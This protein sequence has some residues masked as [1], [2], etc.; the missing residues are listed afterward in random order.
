M[1]KQNN[2][3]Y[4]VY[5]CLAFLPV[6]LASCAPTTGPVAIRNS[7][8]APAPIYGAAKSGVAANSQE[9][10]EVASLSPV[11]PDAQKTAVP[12]VGRLV[13]QAN[14]QVGAAE[15]KKAINTAERGL[16]INRKEPRLYLALAKAYR[17]LSNARQSSYFASQGLRYAQKGGEVFFQLKG[18]F[19]AVN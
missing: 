2:R 14:R 11:R 3:R 12:I 10:T 7:D 19:E 18:M 15:Y 17:G 5:L 16:R 8:S 4:L 13:A 6:L 1:K 9:Q